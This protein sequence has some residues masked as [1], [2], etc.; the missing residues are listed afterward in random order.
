VGM[1]R[2]TELVDMLDQHHL[3]AGHWPSTSIVPRFRKGV[4]FAEELACPGRLL[5]G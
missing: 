4:M 2:T 5:S 3:L 1:Q